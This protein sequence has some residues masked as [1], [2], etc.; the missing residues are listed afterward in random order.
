MR[1][2]EATTLAPLSKETVTF[3][4]PAVLTLSLTY[5]RPTAVFRSAKSDF[6]SL[7]LDAGVSVNVRLFDEAVQVVLETPM[8]LGNVQFSQ[9]DLTVSIGGYPL[10][11]VRT[12]PP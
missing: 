7:S 1:P 5:N 4:Q 2:F 10:T 9:E 6:L 11:V 8:K 3:K 12:P